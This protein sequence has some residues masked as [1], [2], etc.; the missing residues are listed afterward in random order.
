[1]EGTALQREGDAI[2][3]GDVAEMLADLVESNVDAV[4]GH[5]LERLPCPSHP[6]SRVVSGFAAI[7]L[8]AV[9]YVN[10]SC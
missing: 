10:P 5:D 1:M 7:T 3:R 8:A 6:L 2:D 9:G 4:F